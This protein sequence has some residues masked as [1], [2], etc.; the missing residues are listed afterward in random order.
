VIILSMLHILRGLVVKPSIFLNCNTGRMP[1]HL[2]STSILFTKMVVFLN[3]TKYFVRNCVVNLLTMH[4]QI[5]KTVI[6][7]PIKPYKLAQ[8]LFK[9]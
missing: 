8:P 6:F 7:Y 3:L 4:S 5:S 2:K 9:Q 1:Y